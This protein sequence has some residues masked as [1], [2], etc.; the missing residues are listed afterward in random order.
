MQLEQTVYSY[1]IVEIVTFYK[2]SVFLQVSIFLKGLSDSGIQLEEK[3][4]IV[5]NNPFGSTRE[6]RIH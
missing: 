4:P 1:G 5:A 6:E 3:R 2:T